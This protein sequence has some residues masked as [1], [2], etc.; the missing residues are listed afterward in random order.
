MIVTGPRVI[1]GA[2]IAAFLVSLTGPLAPSASAGGVR[3]ASGLSADSTQQAAFAAAARESGVSAPVLL[4][5]SYSTTRWESHAGQPSTTGGF[6]PIHLVDPSAVDGRGD[7]A[8]T[9]PRRSSTLQQGARLIGATAAAVRTDSRTNIRAGAA[10][11]ASYARQLGNGR[12]PATTEGW[13]GAV[14]RFS[15]ATDQLVAQ[16]FADD[17]FAALRTGAARSTSDGQTLRLAA[18]PAVRSEP[19][20]L[21]GLGLKPKAAMPAVECPTRLDCRYIPAAYAQNDPADASDYGNYDMTNRATRPKISYIVIH[22]TEV[23]YDPTIA[24]FQRPTAYVSSHYVLRSSDGQVTQM[25]PT[26]DIA[27]TAGNWYIN[28]H[29]INIEQEGFAAQGAT[30][31]TEAL[32]RSSARL[33]A[34]L[35]ARF[36]IPLDRAHILGHDALPGPI[37]SYT[38]GMHW[39]PGP[40]WDWAHYMELMGA[41]LRATAGPRSNVVTIAPDFAS[42]VQAATG[43]GSDPPSPNEPV[44]FV[45]L[46]TSPSADAPLLSDAALHPD[47]S[48]GTTRMC[49]TSAKAS[50]GQRY[51]VAERQGDWTAIWYRG[52]KAWLHDINVTLPI[53]ASTVTPRPG[54]TSVPV[55]GRA[56]PEASAYAGTSVPVQT[57]SPLQYSI[58]AGQRYVF[59]G[60]VGS[61][62]YRSSTIDGS[63]PGDRT[64]VRGTDRYILIHFGR[65]AAY[66]KASDVVVS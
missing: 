11:L 56:Y 53:K 37:A 66:V 10:L 2:T 5:L 3:P 40:F 48:P 39:D 35:A 16:E 9:G 44:A 43:C 15:G 49:D 6:G 54:L 31:Y 33:V 13:Y 63:G 46:R 58:L 12:L 62:Y 8:R 42:N 21:A 4:A 38:A 36:N 29:P 61:D 60:Q 1:I 28:T 18:Q 7:P 65:R 25:V 34:Y 22:D 51:A 50:T 52:Q 23:L 64:L 57:V 27:W 19:A 59:A 20:Q 26:K 47:G 30:W 55:Y 14:A 24:L 32:Y 17:V 45:Y 41:P